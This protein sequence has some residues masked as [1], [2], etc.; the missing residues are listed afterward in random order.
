MQ[1]LLTLLSTVHS[2]LLLYKSLYHSRDLQICFIQQNWL[3]LAYN[4][5]SL[6][7]QANII[8]TSMHACSAN[9]YWQ[10][11][12]ACCDGQGSTLSSSPFISARLITNP[13]KD[14]RRRSSPTCSGMANYMHEPAAE[15]H[16]REKKPEVPCKP[17]ASNSDWDPPEVLASDE[18]DAQPR[19]KTLRISPAE[20]ERV[21]FS[22]GCPIASCW[23]DDIDNGHCGFGASSLPSVYQEFY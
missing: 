9:C 12:E 13:A 21:V 5:P 11:S 10:A 22:W 18:W 20:L 7:V 19:C 23:A 16:A 14:S 1:W 6:P 3:T 8:Y 2:A 4:G 15:Y 17:M